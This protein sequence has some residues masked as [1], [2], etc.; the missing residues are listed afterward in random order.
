M[1]QIELQTESVQLEEFQVYEKLMHKLGGS[2]SEAVLDSHCDYFSTPEIEGF[3]G[4]R[5]NHG[6]AIVLGDP[7]LHRRK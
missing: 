7:I 3:I 6:C 2:I 5:I 1:Q 4:Y